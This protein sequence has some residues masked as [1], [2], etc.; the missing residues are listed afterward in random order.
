MMK[1]IEKSNNVFNN[2][3]CLLVTWK[4]LVVTKNT[5]K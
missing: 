1:L 5:P 3:A 2:Q 4:R